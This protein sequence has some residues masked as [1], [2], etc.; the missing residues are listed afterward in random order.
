[1]KLV[2]FVVFSGGGVLAKNNWR[3]IVLS[4]RAA[5]KAKEAEERRRRIH[6]V[7]P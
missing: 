2:A 3:L 1:L 4:D 7:Q 5:L 6:L